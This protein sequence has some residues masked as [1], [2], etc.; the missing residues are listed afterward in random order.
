M[1]KS[2]K[3]SIWQGTE[4]YQLSGKYKLIFKWYAFCH[5]PEELKS[6]R[7]LLDVGKDA[8]LTDMYI[9]TLE[10]YLAGS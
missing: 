10:K 9:N 1:G 4:H 6:K 2:L 5:P 8:A 7:L 3:Y